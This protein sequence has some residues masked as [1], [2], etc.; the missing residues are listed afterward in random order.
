MSPTGSLRAGHD[1]HDGP[2][3]PVLPVA[4]HAGLGGHAGGVPGHAAPRVDPAVV[5]MLRV[6]ALHVCTQGVVAVV[7]FC[8]CFL[9]F[10]LSFRF[11][12]ALHPR[13]A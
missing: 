1:S 6:A 3:L 4:G 2:R 9:L 10:F 7:F 8:C 11:S 12:I 13:R 5:P